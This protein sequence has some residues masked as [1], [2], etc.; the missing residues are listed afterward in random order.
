MAELLCTPTPVTTKEGILDLLKDKGG[1]QYYSQMKEMKVDQEALAR[2]LEQTCKSRTRTWLSICAHCAMCADSCFFYRTNNNDPTQIPS[3]KIQSTLGEL[4]RLK[5]KVDAAFMIKC[6]DAAWGKCTCCNRCAVYC[7]H[8]IDTG[9][10]FSYLRGILFKHGFIPWEMKIGSGMHRVYGAQMDVTEEDWLE[11]CEWMVEEHQDEWPDLEIP[12]E[13]EH[14]DVMYVLNAREVKHYP[15]DIAQAAILFHV[16]DT[17][18]T[19]PREGWEN[20]SLTMFAGDWE[21]CS[22]NV[23]RIYAAIDRIKPKVVVGTEC[24][25]AHR[26]TVV[27]GPYWA[28]QESG[29]PPVRFMLVL[30]RRSDEGLRR[31]ST[32]EHYFNLLVFVLFGALGL[33]AWA[34]T[35]SFFELARTFMRQP[36]AA[37]APGSTAANKGGRLITSSPRLTHTMPP[38]RCNGGRSRRNTHESSPIMTGAALLI[39][40][41]E[42]A[43]VKRNPANVH[44]RYSTMPHRA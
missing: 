34:T 13:K 1:A 40:P 4:L 33:A 12:V 15:D 17:N 9:V 29:D 21:G 20:T 10:M 14:A 7:P 19:V 37:C 16:T 42:A 11:T 6:M 3:Y 44:T 30:R 43:L 5:G 39:S 38:M 31:Y 25:H 26:A 23:K 27:E 35:P 18:W 24:G 22:Q 32:P 41:A 36:W 2:D 8:G 28:G